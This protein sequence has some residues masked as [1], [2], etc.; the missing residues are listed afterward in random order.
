MVARQGPLEGHAAIEE[1][2]LIGE[3][4]AISGVHLSMYWHAVRCT[5]WTR[6]DW[7]DEAGNRR[8]QLVRATAA[9][10]SRHARLST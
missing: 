5:F 7:P 2:D 8:G 9:R 10:L 4:D 6:A 3:V 1:C